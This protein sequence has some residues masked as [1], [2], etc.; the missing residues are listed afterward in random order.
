MYIYINKSFFEN[1]SPPRQC[2][3][4][5]YSSNLIQLISR[6]TCRL[7][8]DSTTIVL[9]SEPRHVLFTLSATWQAGGE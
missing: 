8:F 1:L 3:A 9:E 4:R 2:Y 7:T 6:F 5:L